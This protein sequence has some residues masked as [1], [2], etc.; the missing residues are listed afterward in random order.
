MSDLETLK[1]PIGRFTPPA[2]YTPALIK[3][4]IADIAEF[5]SLLRHEVSQLTDEQLDTPY[6]PGGWTIRQVVHHCADSHSNSL[7]RF[8]LA[9][10]EEE[11]TIKPYWEDR[12]AE[13]PDAALPVHPSLLLLEGLHERWV[14]LLNA[15]DASQFEK[16]FIHPEHGKNIS[17]YENTAN[18]SWHGKHHLAHITTLKRSKGW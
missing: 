13:L 1:F 11:P 12:W 6:R 10:T 14:T 3:S 4:Y 18:Y 7:I 17:L 5:P 2:A 15:L 16:V 8:K 9:L